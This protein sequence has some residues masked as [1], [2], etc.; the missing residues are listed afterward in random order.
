LAATALRRLPFGRFRAANWLVRM[1]RRCSPRAPDM[2]WTTLK[3]PA[4][5]AK[6]AC[7]L[8]DSISREIFFNGVYEP[9]EVTI[10][11]SVLTSGMRFVDVGANCGFF[12]LL[13]AGHV[14]TRG[15]VLAFEPDPRLYEVLVRAVEENRLPQVTVLPLAATEHP[16]QLVLMGFEECDGNFGISRVAAARA[17]DDRRSFSV[18]ARP[19]DDVLTEQRMPEVD[20][21]KIDI[22]GYEGFALAGLSRGLAE[23]RVHRLLI[24]FHPAELAAHGHKCEDLALH[25]KQHGYKGWLID[26]SATA[27]RAA[28]YGR[29]RP[30]D[31]IRPF[32]GD[33][34]GWPHTFWVRTDI[35]WSPEMTYT[36]SVIAD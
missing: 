12:S 13:A 24:E 23:G 33:L 20:L 28:V 9:L 5:A 34:T 11:T 27:Y 14:G 26:H 8:R 17:G 7:D 18:A 30:A 4:G 31:L 21:L 32:C 1:R 36:T 3:T 16:G 35:D 2:V 6:L 25:L 15:R 10:L 29:A 19:L 22:E